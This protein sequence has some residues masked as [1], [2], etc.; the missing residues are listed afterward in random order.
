MARRLVELDLLA[1]SRTDAARDLEAY[2]AAGGQRLQSAAGFAQLPKRRRSYRFP[3]RWDPS[4]AWLRWRPISTPRELLPALARNVVT[5]G[6]Q[7]AT[8]N[9][10]LEQTEYLK[11]VIRYL[12][13]ARELDKAGRRGAA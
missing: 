2:R 7:A 5:N 8:S 4:R 12:S 1:G 3:D 6:Y 9:E 13:Q 10:A 11:L